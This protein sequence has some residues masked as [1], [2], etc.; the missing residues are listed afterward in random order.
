MMRSKERVMNAVDHKS[1]D[2]LPIDLWADKIV[3]DRLAEHFGQSYEGVQRLLGVDVRSIRPESTVAKP[4]EPDYNTVWYDEWGVG[5]RRVKT[6]TGYHDDCVFHPLAKVETVREV[7]AYPWPDP[8]SYRFDTVAP[9]C[10]KYEQYA[11]VG[12]N[13]HFFCPGADLRGYETWFIDILEQSDVAEAI[14]HHMQQYWLEYSRTMLESSQDMLDIFY[15]ADDYASQLSM[16]ISVD[17]WRSF[18]RPYLQALVSLGKKH[19]K[20]IFF[21]SCGAV[22]KLIPE[23]IDLGVDILNPI[24]IRAAGMDPEELVREYGRDLCFHGGVDLQHTLCRGTPQDVRDEVHMLIDRL[25]RYNGYII[26]PGHTIISDA[27]M[28]N[29]LALFEAANNQTLRG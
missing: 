20:K 11:L 19:G 23:L 8:K 14:M 3:W 24:Q 10:R 9:L 21:H 16:M 12:G 26:A 6:A 7:E 27:P 29:I 28:E 22:R 25:G 17:C 5:F 13:G 15:L 4:I 2:R 1:V 18:F